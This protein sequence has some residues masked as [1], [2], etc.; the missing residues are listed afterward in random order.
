MKTIDIDQSAPSLKELI[1]LAKQEDEIVLAEGQKPVAK[2]I[3][4]PTPG[5][6][7]VPKKGERVAGLGDRLG[8]HLGAIEAREDFDEALPDEFWLG[9]A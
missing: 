8:L 6:P 9:K 1:Q 4:T 3:F 7:A 5:E 2:V